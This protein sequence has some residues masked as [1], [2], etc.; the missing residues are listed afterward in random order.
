MSKVVIDIKDKSKEK[1]FI[2]FLKSIPFIT[3]QENKKVH[4][5]NISNFR[6][7]FGMWVGRDISLKEIRGKAWNRL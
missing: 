1:T 5:K 3:V 7:S 6:R 4:L 2:S